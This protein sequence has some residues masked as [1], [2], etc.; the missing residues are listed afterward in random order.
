MLKFVTK[1]KNFISKSKDFLIWIYG[2]VDRNC[3]SN[4]GW[5]SCNKFT[6]FIDSAYVSL[7]QKRK[8]FVEDLRQIYVIHDMTEGRNHL[9]TFKKKIR[10]YFSPLHLAFDVHGLRGWYWEV[11]LEAL[12]AQLIQSLK[13]SL[14]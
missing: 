2:E 11:F 7:L 4:K 1:C 3:I 8:E 10:A 12:K 6:I 13:L 5:F 9:R 14:A